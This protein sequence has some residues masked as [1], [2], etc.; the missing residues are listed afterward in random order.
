MAQQVSL[1]PGYLT[2]FS[3]F[4]IFN[5]VYLQILENDFLVIFTKLHFGDLK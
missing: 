3:K 5:R 2:G 1:A 4:P